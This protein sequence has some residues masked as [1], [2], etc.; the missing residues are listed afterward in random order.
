LTKATH[1]SGSSTTNTSF[2]SSIDN[3]NIIII[4]TDKANNINNNTATTNNN[5]NNDQCHDPDKVFIIKTNSNSNSNDTAT[6]T[7]KTYAAAESNG[8][9]TNENNNNTCL[10]LELLK[11]NKQHNDNFL[12]NRSNY[13]HNNVE[14]ISSFDYDGNHNFVNQLSSADGECLQLKTDCKSIDD[15]Y[16][17][18]CTSKYSSG[19]VAT[20][21]NGNIIVEELLYEN[22]KKSVVHVQ[23]NNIVGVVAV[24]LQKPSDYVTTKK[25]EE[26]QKVIT[27]TI[28]AKQKKSVKHKKS[29]K[30]VTFQQSTPD[31]DSS[32][33]SL[34]PS[35]M[36]EESIMSRCSSPG[37]DGND[38]F[39]DCH[40][41]K[42]IIHGITD[43]SDSKVSSLYSDSETD[44]F[45]T[46]TPTFRYNREPSEQDTTEPDSDNSPLINIV[47]EL[48]KSMTVTST[49]TINKAKLKK[50]KS[51]NDVRSAR[52][53][54][55][56][57][58]V[59][60]DS[61]CDEILAQTQHLSYRDY[62]NDKAEDEEQDERSESTEGSQDSQDSNVSFGT[63]EANPKYS[64]QQMGR[65]MARRL[66]KAE[67]IKRL[68][69]NYVNSPKLGDIEENIEQNSFLY[70]RQK[71]VRRRGPQKPPRI[72]AVAMEEPTAQH[73]PEA[74]SG[75]S[76]T[77]MECTDYSEELRK[78]VAKQYKREMSQNAEYEN[79]Q[80]SQNSKRHKQ[81]KGTPQPSC[82]TLEEVEKP[83]VH[84][85]GWMVPKEQSNNSIPPDI[86]NMLNYSD[87]E[88]RKHLII[89]S[90]SKAVPQKPVCNHKNHREV[91]MYPKLDIDA[92]DGRLPSPAPT[93]FDQFAANTRF[94]STP[95]KH[96]P[97][98]QISPIK[99]QAISCKKF[100][101][102]ERIFAEDQAIKKPRLSN[103]LNTTTSD[104]TTC[105]NCAK[106]ATTRKSFRKN[107]ISRT[108][109]F[110][111]TSKQKIASQKIF[112][113]YGKPKDSHVFS[114]PE[115]YCT[116]DKSLTTKMNQEAFL[117]AES[118]KE[119]VK[120]LGWTPEVRAQKTQEKRMTNTPPHKPAR[121]SL[122]F[123][124][125]ASNISPNLKELPKTPPARS[126]DEKFNK[127][128]R[129]PLKKLNSIKLSP[130][131]LFCVKPS[132]S[133]DISPALAANPTYKSFTENDQD[134]SRSI[135]NEYLEKIRVK[136]EGEGANSG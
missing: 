43:L 95:R 96:Q 38:I 106:K 44:D 19:H 14:T 45:K 67:K 55:S 126:F 28:K 12:R 33:S 3:E 62:E 35:S 111:E 91:A 94:Q 54:H 46:A 129:S 17:E 34:S 13:E 123:Q 21:Q 4:K 116:P 135:M 130:K 66:K 84:K 68:Y 134:V 15:P 59:I 120:H 56:R 70:E 112:R 64:G 16:L 103:D 50:I 85:M 75:N 74:I 2:K 136:V 88:R 87:D 51:A 49:V 117:Q 122:H 71:L 60:D 11:E 104:T 93:Q 97:N 9:Q 89:S 128:V 5:N 36:T 58:H 47:Q 25:M 100:L 1:R 31:R 7:T 48:S 82:P 121:H 8:R 80:N 125:A 26:K 65:L 24:E 113:H 18:R 73:H 108:K 37:E 115:T 61:F 10:T 78:L 32:G 98:P 27:I 53:Q 133:Y 110:F 81:I 86:L 105:K 99:K 30:V 127:F 77:T 90:H 57:K 107:A 131:K 39:H 63:L 40:D 83:Q 109:S 101:D 102:M 114:D 29:P 69:A 42:E 132:E 22:N 76:D 20:D 72:F 118:K 119:Q 41:F 124:N 52:K 92:V 79:N 23:R 6:T